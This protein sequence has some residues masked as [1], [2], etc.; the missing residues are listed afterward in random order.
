MQIAGIDHVVLRVR[1]I[2]RM[3]RFYCDVLG[4]SVEKRNE[5]LQMVH[6]RAGGGLIDLIAV[7]GPLGT[8]G[9]GPPGAENR[10]VD[11]ICFQVRDFDL[12][13]AQEHLRAHGVEP[14]PAG[15]R[16]GAGGDGASLYLVDP[17]GNGLELRG[18]S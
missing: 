18:A 14:G 6:L 10:N 11:H 15:N 17:E 3:E 5:R 9:G 1:D 8:M 4:L 12:A 2:E 7:D 13:H 16:F